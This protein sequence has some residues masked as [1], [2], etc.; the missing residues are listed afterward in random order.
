MNV[1]IF[2]QIMQDFFCIIFCIFF[3][4]SLNIYCK[5][6]LILIKYVNYLKIRV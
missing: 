6:R 1:S 4:Y 5:M 2:D 3:W